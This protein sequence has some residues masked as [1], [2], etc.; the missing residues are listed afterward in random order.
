MHESAIGVLERGLVVDDDVLV[1][2]RADAEAVLGG[3]SASDRVECGQVVGDVGVLRE[4]GV[5]P[6]SVKSAVKM[7]GW[8]VPLESPWISHDT[9]RLVPVHAASVSQPL[10]SN[11]GPSS[12]AMT[13]TVFTGS[14]PRV[15]IPIPSSSS[16][17][18]PK[19]ETRTFGERSEVAIRYDV[20]T[21]AVTPDGVGLRGIQL[22]LESGSVDRWSHLAA[23]GGKHGHRD[24]TFDGLEG[25]HLAAG[26]GELEH[27]IVTAGDIASDFAGEDPSAK[28][29]VRC[30]LQSRESEAKVSSSESPEGTR[31]NSAW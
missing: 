6:V 21:V 11:G 24:Q 8:S 28:A 22:D 27:F 29:R 9:C 17:I 4:V 20:G 1:V 31:R 5:P 15:A 7:A 25:E 10:S 14:S 19:S 26:G 16:D 18:G 30:W 2:G 3:E 13:A 12:K 23:V